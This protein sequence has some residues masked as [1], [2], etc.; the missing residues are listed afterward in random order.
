[1]LD[2][3]LCVVFV[4]IAGFEINIL[5][6]HLI[7]SAQLAGIIVS[8]SWSIIGC[9]LNWRTEYNTAKKKKIVYN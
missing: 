1:M 5:V 6:D 8:L 2:I 7:K 9:H 3:Y 4:V